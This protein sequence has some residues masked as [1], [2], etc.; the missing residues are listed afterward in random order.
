M[1]VMLLGELG[2]IAKEIE[3]NLA[4]AHLVHI[5]STEQKGAG[6]FDVVPMLLGEGANRGYQ[7][8]AAPRPSR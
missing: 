1:R 2:G 6:K 7:I 3:E 5:H 4:Q 8:L